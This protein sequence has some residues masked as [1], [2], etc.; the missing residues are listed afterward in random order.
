VLLIIYVFEQKL[1]M[2]TMAHTLLE[3]FGG[4]LLTM[5][6]FSDVLLALLRFELR[7]SAA[8]A[9]SDLEKSY[10][11]RLGELDQTGLTDIAAALR[12]RDKNAAPPAA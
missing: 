11:A 7:Q 10:D 1:P 4:V 3:A 8:F 9:G 6:V 12:L 5:V 2:L